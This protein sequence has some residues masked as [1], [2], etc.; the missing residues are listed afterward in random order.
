[1][2]DFEMAVPLIYPQ[3]TVLYMSP[4]SGPGMAGIWNPFLDALDGSYCNFSSHG[5]TGD[6]P[7]IDGTFS[8]HDCGTAA[9][10]NVISISYGST[11]P[12]YPARYGCVSLR[13]A[14]SAIQVCCDRRVRALTGVLYA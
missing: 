12:Y 6:T 8:R 2:L 1:M 11:E 9:R 14:L 10:T 7:K 3:S 13:V 4:D 5:Y